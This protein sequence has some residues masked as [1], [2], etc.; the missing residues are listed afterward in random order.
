M[1][2]G[3][4]GV[5]VRLAQRTLSLPGPAKEREESPLKS[6]EEF[7]KHR[8][9]LFGIAYRMVGSAT[10]ADDLVQETLLRWQRK[11]KL[12]LA[13][14]WLTAVITRLSIDFL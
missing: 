12:R 13:D 14:A 10:D 8:S 7:E 3:E 11:S 6:T 5:R 9:R 1:V 4:R 2:A